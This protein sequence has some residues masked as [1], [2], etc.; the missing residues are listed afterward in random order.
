M[1]TVWE[2]VNIIYNNL[3][4]INISAI[5]FDTI[6]KSYYEG[7]KVH[8]EDLNVTFSTPED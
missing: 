6:L 8:L 4:C 7:D 1:S 5:S 3:Q 2:N